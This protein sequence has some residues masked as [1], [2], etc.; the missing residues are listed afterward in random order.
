MVLGSSIEMVGMT[1]LPTT[2]LPAIG[3]LM[4]AH[5]IV[6]NNLQKAI[7]SMS[8]L[9]FSIGVSFLSEALTSKKLDIF[10]NLARTTE[11]KLESLCKMLVLGDLVD[12]LS[13][14]RNVVAHHLP[15]W[16][17]KDGTE[18]GYWKDANKTFPQIRVQPPFKASISS[19]LALANELETVGV[20]LGIIAP[21]CLP[22]G[23][24]LDGKDLKQFQA[25]LIRHP[26]WDD[27]ALF[28]WQEKFLD[29]L[30]NE[31]H[32]PQNNHRKPKRQ[33]KSSR[34]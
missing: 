22:D 13:K 10:K 1:L 31:Y 19:I 32:K 9:D 20:W 3:K 14:D 23:A 21:H 34:M 16:I 28:P 4:V 26:M 15:D 24:D 8:K 25:Q 12:A 27:D 18:I 7:F 33:P 29:K 5:T 30:K 2:F 11:H 17:N 6:D